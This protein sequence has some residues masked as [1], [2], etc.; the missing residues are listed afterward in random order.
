HPQPAQGTA[1]PGIS[2]LRAADAA[3]RLS[4]LP[5][6]DPVAPGQ[7]PHQPRQGRRL[8]AAAAGLVA[9]VSRA[10]C[11]GQAARRARSQVGGIPLD[12]RGAA[13]VAVGA[14]AEDALPGLVQT[15][16]QGLERT[17]LKPASRPTTP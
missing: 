16:R 3:E 8:A 14:A 7:V 13:R 11:S 15:P 4:P 9:G 6:S 2:L 10:L 12:A 17:R 1:S 5:E